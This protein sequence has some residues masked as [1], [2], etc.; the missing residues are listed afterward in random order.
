[1]K[2]KVLIFDIDNTIIEWKDEYWLALKSTLERI[3]Y[4]I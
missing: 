3:K 4:S 1:M 2:Y